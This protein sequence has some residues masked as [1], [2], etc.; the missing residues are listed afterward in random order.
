MNQ[1]GVNQ[2]RSAAPGPTAHGLG[3]REGVA[4]QKARSQPL[5][6]LVQVRR[7]SELGESASIGSRRA[8]RCE[9]SDRGCRGALILRDP[10]GEPVLRRVA[11][12]PKSGLLE[13]AAQHAV[14]DR[15]YW[16]PRRFREAKPRRTL[17]SSSSS[18]GIAADDDPRPPRRA[19]GA[20][21]RKGV[22]RAS[23]G[24]A[25]P[26]RGRST[27]VVVAHQC[28]SCTAMSR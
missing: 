10:V 19:N 11:T 26:A 1:G 2:E 16:A 20:S 17:R 14:R 3:E 22:S 13:Q 9:R 24:A 7:C 21:I 8:P 28:V 27:R 5:A 15:R 23:P 25:E 4:H 12:P 18:C 6:R